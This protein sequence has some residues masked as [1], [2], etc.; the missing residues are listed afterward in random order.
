V[1]VDDTDADASHNTCCPKVSPIAHVAALET[2]IEELEDLFKGMSGLLNQ[3]VKWVTTQGQAGE[4]MANNVEEMREYLGVVPQQ[5]LLFNGVRSCTI[6]R[7]IRT[8][9]RDA[10]PTP[11]SPHHI[12][13]TL[14]LAS[15]S[16][17]ATAPAIPPTSTTAMPMAGL[18]EGLAIGLPSGSP[19]PLATR[20]ASATPPS[21]WTPTICAPAEGETT[22][23]P[24]GSAPALDS[25]PG[26]MLIPP[27]PQTS[28]DTATY[29][30][31]PLVP[32]ITQ[33]AGN[34]EEIPGAADIPMAVV[35][36]RSGGVTSAKAG[37]DMEVRGGM[38]TTWKGWRWRRLPMLTPTLATLLPISATSRLMLV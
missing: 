30:P 35:E 32:S 37:G 20:G 24:T 26:V 15:N 34:N 4:T 25:M 38:L 18:E 33:A 19:P 14:A 13:E 5:I 3:V 31:V 29:A 7:V 23:V 36:G 10:D 16:A 8:P 9:P 21:L 12:V 11:S 28:Q 1:P 27:T 17:A 2:R 6:Y 22:E